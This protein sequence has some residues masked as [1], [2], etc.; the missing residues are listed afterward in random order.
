MAGFE[1]TIEDEANCEI[2][3]ADRPL[4]WV[5]ALLTAENR[6][7][8]TYLRQSALARNDARYA[9]ATS[10]YHDFLLPLTKIF[11]TVP[12][13]KNVPV[14]IMLDDANRLTRDQQLIINSWIANRDQDYV[15]LKVASEFDG[16]KTFR[17]M[18]E[19]FGSISEGDEDL[20]MERGG[21]IESPH[22]YSEVNVDELYTAA[23]ADYAEKVHLIANRRLNL[24]G[25]EVSDIRDF[26]P[27]NR[28]ESLLFDSIKKDVAD[29]WVKL[30]KPGARDDY[31]YRYGAARLFQHLKATKKRKSYAG[32]S[33]MVHLSA[34]IIRGFLEP[35]YFM[36][37]KC[38][39]QNLNTKT[40]R[41]IPPDIQD[42]V[43]FQYSEEFLVMDLEKI[44][45]DLPP[46]KATYLEALSTLLESLG[47]LFYERL[48]DPE[49]R[50]ARLFSF[51]VRGSLSRDLE[52]VLRLGVRYRYFQRRTYSTK[53]GGGREKWF[54]LNRRLC[55][56]FK[57]D[58]TGF[59]GRISL[60]AE[61]LRIACENPERFVRFRL[62]QD[63]RQMDMFS[64]VE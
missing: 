57:L 44:R 35:C 51:T 8:N 20:Y 55:P 7:V 31:V 36:F 6:K 28:T 4:E 52:E 37:D 32:F 64:L 14:Y 18:D 2:A 41:V 45:K 39:S 29:E 5:Q 16:Y 42:E 61:L 60:T 48:H 11:R 23:K 1:V 25:S 15:C 50:E 21:I 26:L 13:F 59:E 22:D 62:H 49:S 47:R 24:Y 3:L 56:V 30:G 19:L 53:E 17:K 54:I 40:I 38:L 63:G 9:G 58:P 34:G 12:E 46:E 33:N 27:P 10:G 43:L